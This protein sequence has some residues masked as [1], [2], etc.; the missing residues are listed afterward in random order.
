M[1]FASVALGFFLGWLYCT[2][3][4]QFRF[5]SESIRLLLAAGCSVSA[6]LRGEGSANSLDYV[7]RSS[8]RVWPL[9]LDFSTG[10][11]HQN[12]VC[13]FVDVQGERLKFLFRGGFGP[14]LGRAPGVRMVLT[15]QQV[16]FRRELLPGQPYEILTK[17]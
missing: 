15:D 6:A 13:Y 5:L 12:N 14:A 11:L 3:C 4:W 7:Q 1:D 2:Q 17:W 8:Q 10:H 9:D 16:R